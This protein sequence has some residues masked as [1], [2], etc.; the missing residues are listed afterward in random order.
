MV[1][2][3]NSYGFKIMGV[4]NIT[5]DSFSD[6]GAYLSPLKA[7]ER[8]VEMIKIGADFV[9]IGAESTRPGATPLSPEEEW[10]RLEPVLKLVNEHQIGQFIT[11][12][13]M[14]PEIMER[15]IDWRIAGI[16]DVSGGT[17]TD[18][19][20]RLRRS[21][22]CHHISMHMHGN[23]QT[24]QI[25]PLDGTQA[26]ERVSEFFAAQNRKLLECGFERGQFWLDPGIGFGKTDQAN[27]C[28]MAQLRHW[29]VDYNVAIGI[30]R[31]SFIGRLFDLSTPLER[32][33]PSKS[34]ELGLVL[35]GARLIR[36]HEIKPLVKIRNIL[37]SS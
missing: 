8:A 3:K 16:N 5:P 4:V 18:L 36:T 34:M 7:L 25:S 27:L 32:D 9:D 23:P 12:D 24:M 21:G 19:L 28:L 17:P 37:M 1:L 11:V 35:S 15:L 22:I 10:I 30:S 33:L 31:K 2:G 6:G 14:K 26:I 29:C 20:Y 13:T